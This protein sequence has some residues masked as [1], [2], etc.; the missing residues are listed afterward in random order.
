MK[1]FISISL[2]AFFMLSPIIVLAATTSSIQYRAT[3]VYA[4][5]RTLG[6]LP[7]TSITTVHNVMDSSPGKVII[8]PQQQNIFGYWVNA[9]YSKIMGTEV[10]TFQL[11]KYAPTKLW[12]EASNVAVD[13]HGYFTNS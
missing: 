3:G 7:S 4:G 2:F 13:V 9:S 5:I 8:T 6:T 11:N 10:H 1:R 12:L